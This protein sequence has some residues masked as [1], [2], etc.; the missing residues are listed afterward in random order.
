L[1][2]DTK[3]GIRNREDIR[4]TVS[5]VLRQHQDFGMHKDTH[6]TQAGWEI[7]AVLLV[8]EIAMHRRTEW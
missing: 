7:E 1:S 6:H 3:P 8:C 2:D 4:P 5:V